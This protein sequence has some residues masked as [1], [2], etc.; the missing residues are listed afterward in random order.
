[1][2]SSEIVGIL[3]AEEAAIRRA[4]RESLRTAAAE[5]CDKDS[6]SSDSPGSTPPPEQGDCI[7][8]PLA[9]QKTKRTA[10]SNSTSTLTSFSDIGGGKGSTNVE[11]AGVVWSPVR[12][13]S[14][15]P[16]DTNDSAVLSDCGSL[17]L[18]LSTS[19]KSSTCSSRLSV[20]R[21]SDSLTKCSPKQLSLKSPKARKSLP[22]GSSTPKSCKSKLS[23]GGSCKSSPK[24]TGKRLLDLGK[25]VDEGSPKAKKRKIGK[26][27]LSS[28]HQQDRD[29]VL[30][31][32]K[33]KMG[34]KHFKN[35]RM[36]KIK[37]SSIRLHVPCTVVPESVIAGTSLD[38]N[39]GNRPGVTELEQ[40]KLEGDGCQEQKR[41]FSWYVHLLC[42]LQECCEHSST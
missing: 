15:S 36:D 34:K 38:D 2:Q 24:Q 32:E 31:V 5:R 21:F 17:N 1:M 28:S 3:P 19:S 41:P 13:S 10:H 12:L 7:A 11:A 9:K 16:D 4:L 22:A 8:V 42:T 35:K 25:F 26:K 27:L 6:S 20:P 33:T 29:E 40:A 14:R 30:K 18:V 39:F 37:Q 23:K